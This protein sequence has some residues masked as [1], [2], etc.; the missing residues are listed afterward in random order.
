MRTK[1]QIIDELLKIVEEQRQEIIQLK[2]R[3]SELERRL[4]LSCGNRS[5]GHGCH[6]S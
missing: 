4:N 3:I 5:Y 2:E 6:G 1:D